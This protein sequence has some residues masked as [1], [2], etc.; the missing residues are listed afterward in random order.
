MVTL[1]RR[2]VPAPF[3]SGALLALW[4]VLSRSTSLGQVILGLALAIVVPLITENLRVTTGRAHRPLL[5]VRFIL[6][7]VWDVLIAN[8]E[9][10]RGVVL[11]RWRR[12]D[13]R[14]VRV[15]LELRHPLGLT[16]LA[17]VTTIVP[18]TVWSEL[19]LDRSALLLHVWNVEEEERFVARYKARYEQPL[20]RIFE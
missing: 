16:A 10:A 1:V 5:A 18:G 4:L 12:P 17:M 7:V 14:F 20:K 6:T 11:W 15:P 3:L 2:V 13:A 19:A 9:V 8:L